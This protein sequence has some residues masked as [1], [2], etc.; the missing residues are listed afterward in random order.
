M[1]FLSI[2]DVYGFKNSIYVS[3]YALFIPI[4]VICDI[5]PIVTRLDY[6]LIT[7]SFRHPTNCMIYVLKLP[8]AHILVCNDLFVLSHGCIHL[9]GVSCINHG[10]KLILL[11]I[12][13]NSNWLSSI[14]KKGEIKSASRSLVGFG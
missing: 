12:V 2:C 9:G 6:H 13:E 1:R 10:I 8:H 11:I 4:Y 14:T 7:L 3:W 5:Y